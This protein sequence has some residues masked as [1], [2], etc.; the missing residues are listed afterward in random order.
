MYEYDG[1]GTFTGLRVFAHE[2]LGV[3]RFYGASECA[4]MWKK[5]GLDEEM[6]MELRRAS[7]VAS[8][9]KN[10][11]TLLRG[12]VHKH[13]DE[14]KS[15]GKKRKREEDSADK[16]TR[17]QETLERAMAATGLKFCLHCAKPFSR[18]DAHAAH[19]AVCISK[20]AERDESRRFGRRRPVRELEGSQVVS[21]QQLHFSEADT[22]GPHTG[23]LLG[24]FCDASCSAVCEVLVLGLLTPE[25]FQV[26]SRNV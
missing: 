2:G 10:V 4:E 6:Q 5:E 21:A 7:D 12:D 9:Y 11:G 18:A 14:E 24:V 19:T 16:Q 1:E 13:E 3:G 23:V 20:T 26:S 22:R 17:A 8:T 25:L 15:A